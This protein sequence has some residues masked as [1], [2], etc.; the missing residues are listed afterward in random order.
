MKIGIIMHP[1]GEKK[2]G[3]LPRIIFGWARALLNV[4]TKN[5]YLIYFKDAITAPPDLPG[6][7]WST[8]ALGRGRFWLNRL[9]HAP[10]ADVYLFNTPVL[11]LFWKPKKAVI[12]ALDYPYKYLKAESLK[13]WLFRFFISWYHG[14]SLRR[15]DHIISVS[16]STKR[17]TMKFFGVPES[18][19]TTVYHGFTDVCKIPEVRVSIPEKFFFFA[20]T[21][22]ERKNVHR[23][24]EGFAHFLA[25][26]PEA[27][28]KIVIGGINRGRYYERV[29]ASIKEKNL[30]E[31]VVFL[32]H[33]S[34]GQMSFV[35]KRAEALVFPSI[36]EGTGFPILEA[37]SCGAPAIT[38]NI[39]GPAELG[40]N[41]GGVL[42]DPYSSQAIGEAMGRVA[43]DAVFREEQVRRGYEQAK[44]FNW[45]NTGRETLAI[46]E[47]I[48]RS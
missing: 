16:D 11:P 30:G 28:H 6:S 32:G 1:Y 40:A 46:L 41:G 22:K 38:S 9:K 37:M 17:D 4:D 3:G 47:R 39:F 5:E 33:L 13:Q 23:I 24:I 42:V 44:R 15:A 19:I 18:K 2:P 45:E 21:I 27:V 12:I 43:F 7:H 36:V 14:Y 48:A 25:Q 31:K 20:G 10:Q 29:L 35:Y 34:E 26:H 8:H